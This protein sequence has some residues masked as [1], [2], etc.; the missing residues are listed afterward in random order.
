VVKLVQVR[1]TDAAK[2]RTDKHL[3]R[4]ELAGF[5]YVVNTKVVLAMETNGFH[6]FL[7]MKTTRP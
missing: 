3:V 7:K 4:C 2:R 1:A 6:L 5:F